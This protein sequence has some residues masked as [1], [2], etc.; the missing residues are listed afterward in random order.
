VFATVHTSANHPVVIAKQIATLDQIGHGRAG[1]N[2]V[3]GWNKPEYEALG[4]TLPQS[5]EA[6]YAYAQEW[7]DIIR[8]IWH[9]G[10]PFDWHGKAFELKG[11][12][13]LP[14]PWNGEQ[15]PILNAAG[16][17]EGREFA[18]KNA[19]FLFTPAIDL[20]RS[21]AEV[22]ELRAQG[23]TH[24]R[25]VN[26]LTFSH[27]VCRPTEKEAQDYLTYFG[28]TNADWAAVD[29][30]V[31]LQFANA[32]SFP[33]DLLA[34]IRDRMAA[35]HG[36]FPLVGTP[37]QVA[38]GIQSLADAGFKGT[39]LSFVDYVEEFPYFR[40]N[41]LPLLETRGLRKPVKK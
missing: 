8:K 11:A 37:E 2:I 28:K 6:R 13:G 26:V 27:V 23:R 19:N 16:S 1:L 35:G 40:D 31:D 30:L 32:H 36:G 15:P 17:V 34:L 33:H 22:A 14:T 29:N 20:A 21:R 9:G 41:V 5:H 39:T 25:D 7:F 24:N 18:V 12:Y 4:L 3:A 38:D 10:G